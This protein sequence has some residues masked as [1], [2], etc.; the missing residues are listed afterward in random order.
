MNK[1]QERF[2]DQLENKIDC[3]VS[4]LPIVEREAFLWEI[5]HRVLD[6]IGKQERW[7]IMNSI[8]NIV[9]DEK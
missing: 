3:Y 8:F 2:L 7:K 1:L 4:S 5:K 9:N 6:K